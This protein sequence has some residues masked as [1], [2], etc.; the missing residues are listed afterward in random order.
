M[1]SSNLEN[2][3]MHTVQTIISQV[4]AIH[5]QLKQQKENTELDDKQKAHLIN[6]SNYHLLVL[7]ILLHDFQDFAR[8]NFA[9]AKEIIDWALAFY[10]WGVQNGQIKLCSCE[11]CKPITEDKDKLEI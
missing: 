4:V 5:T 7:S 6:F 11:K 10:D 1:Q 9:P 8:A 3:V 2:S